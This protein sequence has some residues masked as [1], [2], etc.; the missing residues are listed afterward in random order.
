[1]MAQQKEFFK[2]ITNMLL[3]LLGFIETPCNPISPSDEDLK[4]YQEFHENFSNKSPK[5]KEQKYFLE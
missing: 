1:M 2:K 4:K 3:S 5:Y